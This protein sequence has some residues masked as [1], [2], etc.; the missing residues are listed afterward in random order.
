[1]SERHQEGLAHLLY[2]INMGG[3]F[4]ALTGEVGTGKTTLCRCLL[5]QLPVNVDIALILNPKL[6]A[7]ELLSSICDELGIEYAESPLSLKHFVDKINHYL[8]TAYAKGRTTVLLIDEAQNLSLEV[9][10]QIRLLTNLETSKTKLLQIVLVGQPELKHL[11]NRQKLRQ[12]NQRITARYHLLPLSFAETRAYIQHRLAV[13]HGNPDLFKDSAIRKVYQLSAGVPRIIN[14]L[15]DRAMLGAYATNV[16]TISPRIIGRAATETLGL[17]RSSRLLMVV[18]AMLVGL[19]MAMVSYY[20]DQLIPLF[21]QGQFPLSAQ[22]SIAVKEQTV[23]IRPPISEPKSS[24]AKTEVIAFGSWLEDPELSL[25]QA[26]IQALQIWKKALPADKQA[27]CNYVISVGLQCLFDKANWRELL[28]LD[29]PAILE[30]ALDSDA[31]RYALLTGIDKGQ[32]VIHFNGDLSFPM[33]EVMRFWN[34]NFLIL[35]QPPLSGLQAIAPAQQSDSVLWLREQLNLIEGGEANAYQSPL[36]D[37][38]LKA[39]VIEFQRRHHL[40]PDGIVGVRTLIHLIN[41]TGTGDS[42]HLK[43]TQ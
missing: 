29:R 24:T 22:R 32:A 33:T 8:L 14:I 40:T 5:E 15:C 34:G 3:G 10:E 30:F 38:P 21:Q 42:P 2:G 11:L 28:L 6:N 23:T 12:L 7:I 17:A 1:M 19:S 4:V 41:E 39:K 31:K 9:L 43:I 20:W 26:M 18:M 16:Q 25:N 13:C 36:F 27:S 37:E 35:W